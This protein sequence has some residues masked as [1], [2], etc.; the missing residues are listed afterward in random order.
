MTKNLN[1]RIRV[2][3]W[4]L[5]VLF[6][7]AYLFSA[8]A[9]SIPGV[10]QI[11][12]ELEGIPMH[13]IEVSTRPHGEVDIVLDGVVDEA[14]WQ[15]IPTFDNMIVAVPGTG[16]KGEYATEIR[17]LATDKGMYVS[18]V[19]K[20]PVDSLVRRLTPRDQFI[21]RDTFGVT[22]D[23]S[24][25]GQ[26][27]YWFIVALGDPVMDGKVLPERRYTNDWDGP[28]IGKSAEFSGGWSVEMYLPWSMMNL[29]K[30]EQIRSIGFAASRQVSGRNQRYQWPGHSYSSSRFVTALNTMMVEG[31]APR[32]RWS[33][34]PFASGTVDSARDENDLRI[35]MD[36]S[37]QPLPLLGVN[38]TVNPDFGAVEA[39]DVVLNLTALETFFPE[40]RLFFLEG[41][42]VFETTPRANSGNS[43]REVTNE[44]FATTSR[45]VFVRDFL[46]APISL[47]NTR[48]IGGTANQVTVP[49]GLSVN[50]GERDLPTSL[51]G[52]VKLTGGQGGF[53]YGA[54]SAFEDDVSW[55]GSDS[56]G[57]TA[58][59]ADA[60]RDFSVLR[61][62]Y[63]QSEH[64]RFGAGY[65]GTRVAGPQYDAEVHG[66]D[67]H[68]GKKSGA[69]G[70]DLQV[71]ESE[72]G[73]V[74][75]RGAV[76]DVRFAPSAALQHKFEYE[77]FDANVDINDLGFLLRNNYRGGQ[78]IL[79]YANP[80]P[81]RWF[82][83]TRGTVV[84]R[85]QENLSKGQVVDQGIFWRNTLVLSGRNT[86]RTG[87]GYL[88]ERFDDRN[89]R[90][91]GAYKTADRLWWDLLWATDASRPVS[92]SFGVG[93]LQEDLG[94]W[95]R[96]FLVG[97]TARISDRLYF[98]LDVSYKRR[99]GW[100]VYQGARSF[101]S[102]DAVD[103][104]PSFD[105][106]WML[107][108]NHQ[109]KLSFQWAGVKAYEQARFIVPENDGAL[110][111]VVQAGHQR[112]RF[113]VSLL[114]TQLRY[115]WEIAPLTDFYVVYNRG[116]QLPPTE[117][118]HFSDLL[119]DAFN[120]PIINALV[121]KLRYRFGS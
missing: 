79:G 112:N 20:Q 58:I 16:A 101:G 2:R 114:T 36:V 48:R 21:D 5:G 29:P 34:I 52:A 72:V 39:D 67:L 28:W 56:D 70:A 6:F 69:F 107:A 119:G 12:G 71:L 115:R 8:P 64:D 26:F 43:F 4:R 75:G 110:Q 38:A 9:A 41:S 24:G 113:T 109:I 44:N 74:S 76:L 57:A 91:N 99:R 14:V 66:V 31:V 35:G 37:W 65:L 95:T 81:G 11:K 78:Y 54:L 106:N 18:S 89:S 42:E 98:D 88:P 22:L 100:M 73:G 33:L 104:Q 85:H 83:S 68:Y 51:L 97:M 47:L 10:Q 46:P 90:G 3:G 19:M 60:G 63:E 55:I 80:K 17:W 116:N 103:L 96:K 59:I 117:D 111:T 49:G 118:D 121:V 93:G 82:R 77:Y 50:R 45:R 87:L 102:F 120:D 30:S 86:V 108:A 1:Q 62:L 84:V 61:L 15:E 13:R 32:Q 53:R 25:E 40:K 7:S 92:L 105:L 23:T 94:G 27:A